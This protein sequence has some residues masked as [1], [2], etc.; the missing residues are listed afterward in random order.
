MYD[1][2]KTHEAL[3]CHYLNSVKFNSIQPLLKIIHLACRKSYLI[4]ICPNSQER[5][6][7]N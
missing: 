5:S 4:I 3:F 7:K 2:N 1:I 6:T